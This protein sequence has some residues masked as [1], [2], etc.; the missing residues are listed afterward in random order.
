EPFF[1]TKPEDKGSGLSLSSVLGIVAAHNGAMIVRSE[2]GKGTSFELFFPVMEEYDLL[3]EN[4]DT[5]STD[6][7]AG[8]QHKGEGHILL[9]EDE[10]RVR[11][12]LSKMLGR[13]GYE[14]YSCTNGGEAIDHLREN[15]DRYS[16][17]L[18]DYT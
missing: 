14:V 12:M 4:T 10:E 7:S 11:T 13:M 1:T 2:P 6:G 3:N 5:Q 18:S 8:A 16:L 9:V 17:I 15:P